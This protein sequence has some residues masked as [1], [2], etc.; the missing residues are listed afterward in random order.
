[1]EKGLRRVARISL[2]TNAHVRQWQ[3][4]TKET[5]MRCTQTQRAEGDA[6]EI[7]GLDIFQAGRRESHTREIFVMNSRAASQCSSLPGAELNFRINSSVDKVPHLTRLLITLA[8]KAS[9]R[10]A[11]RMMHRWYIKISALR[12]MLRCVASRCDRTWS[13]LRKN[14]PRTRWIAFFFHV[15]FY[16]LFHS[17][18]FFSRVILSPCQ[19]GS[20]A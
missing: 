2:A 15:F 1:M 8:K 12:V 16:S 7:H 10:T 4:N 19:R 20:Y 17:S 14:V 9:Q 6:R 11:R 3:K 5:R 18:L 13:R